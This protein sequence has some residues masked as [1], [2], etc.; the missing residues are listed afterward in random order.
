MQ[1][2]KSNKFN[3][4]VHLWNFAEIISLH[5]INLHLIKSLNFIILSTLYVALNDCYT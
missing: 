2:I 4:I 1:T 3:Y 5:Y